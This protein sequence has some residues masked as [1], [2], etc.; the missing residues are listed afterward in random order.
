VHAYRSW[1][2]GLRYRGPDGT[3]RGRYCARSLKIGTEVDLI[4][5][6]NNPQDSHAVAVKHLG[7]H[8]GYIPARHSWVGEAL[9]DEGAILNCTVDKIE[10]SGWLFV[11]AS[12]I[13]LS[14][15]INGRREAAKIG[16]SSPNRP[17]DA[18]RQKLEQKAR[19]ACLDG[20]RI[21]DYVAPPTH[22]FSSEM[23]IEASYVEARLA[24][25]GFEHDPAL[26]DMLIGVAQGLIVRKPSFVRAVN[27]IAVHDQHY[28]L[29]C[30]AA[31]ELAEI[32]GPNQ[33][34]SEAL[35]RL[36]AAGNKLSKGK[37]R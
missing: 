17:A 2:A 31:K 13:G 30:E 25:S 23:N 33:F 15:T 11:R 10:T 21:L 14:V 20:L 28:K 24:M 26:V 18:A 36:L 37:R 35:S 5:E 7:H 12:F 8:L 16:I 3:N 22:S 34:Q 4:P 32:S 27:A 29:V 19:E 1:I 6:P 9:I